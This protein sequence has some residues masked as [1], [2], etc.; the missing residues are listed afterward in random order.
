[1]DTL[2]VFQMLVRDYTML[3]RDCIMLVRDCIAFL[4][5]RDGVLYEIEIK[6]AECPEL[7]SGC[8]EA[9]YQITN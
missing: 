7:A 1:M 3:V 4:V 6:V 2:L 9:P 8:I 5:G